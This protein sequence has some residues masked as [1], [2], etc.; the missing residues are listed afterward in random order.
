METSGLGGRRVGRGLRKRLGRD[1]G[2]GNRK[3]VSFC[4]GGEECVV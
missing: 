1:G 2:R 3:R 4:G